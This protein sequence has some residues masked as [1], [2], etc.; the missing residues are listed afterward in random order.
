MGV[1]WLSSLSFSHLDAQPECANPGSVYALYHRNESSFQR[2]EV[3]FDAIPQW[4]RNHVTPMIQLEWR[5]K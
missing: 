5:A 1:C 3:I 4:A 2:G